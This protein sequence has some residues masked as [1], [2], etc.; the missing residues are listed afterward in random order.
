MQLTHHIIVISVVLSKVRSVSPE[1]PTRTVIKQEKDS[2]LKNK[3]KNKKENKETRVMSVPFESYIEVP[4][5]HQVHH[6]TNTYVSYTQREQRG[7]E[8]GGRGNRGWRVASADAV[9]GIAWMGIPT[10]YSSTAAG[11]RRRGPHL[12]S[13]QV[14]LSASAPDLPEVA[15][16]TGGGSPAATLAPPSASSVSGFLPA[17]R[18]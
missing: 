4:W 14:L 12:P 8:K 6:P 9:D 5:F 18:P 15:S 1:V 13:A 7:R 2:L 10:L 3:E 11:R 17:R 16:V